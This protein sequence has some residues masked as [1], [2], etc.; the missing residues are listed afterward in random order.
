MLTLDVFNSDPFSA[1]SLSAAVD[2]VAY[3]PD[4]L[5]GFPDLFEPVPV[6][7]ETILIE[8]RANAPALIQT[9]PRGAPPSQKGGDLRQARSFNTVRFARSARITAN[10]L[11]N[12]RAFGQV[13]ELQSLQMEVARR[14]MLIKRDF[15]L[16]KE[17]MLFNLVTQGKA[18]DAANGNA[19]IYDW[20]TEFNQTLP[21]EVAFDFATRNAT[22]NV[23]DGQIRVIC[24][25]IVRNLKKSLQG[26]GGNRVRVVAICGDEFWDKLTSSLE[27]RATYHNWMAAQDLRNDVGKAWS[28]FRYGDIEFFNYRG[29]DDQA[30]GSDSGTLGLAHDKAKFFPVGA[31]IFQWAL[32]PAERFEFVN[33]PGQE[34]YAWV[35][36]DKDRNSYVDIEHYSYPLP[37]CV[38]PQSLFS[39]RDE[40]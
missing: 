33:T 30:S 8:Q 18:I 24:N 38:Q 21:T 3:V 36:P 37:V 35:V 34:M 27:V 2:K 39:A 14:T 11:Q 6:P 7:T 29:T 19:V 20:S 5:T 12:I 28:G 15:A 17:A 10:Q 13:S 1:I 32:A 26:L 40:A 4:F 16:T 31:G 9:S 25:T 23:G 22:A